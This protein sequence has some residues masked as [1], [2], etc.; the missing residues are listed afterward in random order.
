MKFDGPFV[1]DPHPAESEG[2]DYL[3]LRAINL[4]M[5]DMMLPGINNVVAMIRPFSLMAWVAWRFE[6]GAATWAKVSSTDFELFKQKV[7]TVFVFSH[8]NAGDAEGLPGRQQKVPSGKIIR[9]QFRDFQRSGSILDAALYGPSIKNL[10]G[11]GFLSGSE[12]FQSLFLKVTTSGKRLAL[13]LDKLLR[14]HLSGQQ[15]EFISSLTSTEAPQELIDGKFYSA[16]CISSVSAEEQLAFRERLHQPQTIG[17][18]HNHARRAAV[19]AYAL[20]TLREIGEPATASELRS[21]MTRVLPASLLQTPQSQTFRQ[22]QRHWQLLQVRQAQRLGLEV[23]FGWVERCLLYSQVTSVDNLAEKAMAALQ[24]QPFV[25]EDARYLQLQMSRLR[26]I[27][28]GVD[29]LFAKDR[30]QPEHD[31][32][33]LCDALEAAVKTPQPSD[34]MLAL[35]V[36]LLLI[37]VRFAQAFSEDPITKDEVGAGARFRLPLGMWADFITNHEQ[38]PLSFV[39]HKVFSSF[40]ISQHLGVAASRSRDEKS[41]MRMSIEDRGLTSLLPNAGK[42]LRPKRT[43]DRLPSA[44]ALMAECGLLQ[45]AAPTPN[46]KDVAY[47]VA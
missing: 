28:G 2:V 14:Q 26:A 46:S 8:V 1:V 30:K 27:E 6:E 17:E 9:F 12:A 31:L 43:Q 21:A 41:R 15:Y 16:W 3:G 35:A 32:F 29:E 19:L 18:P 5:M 13:A 39:L 24:V 20:E 23:L 7:E 44:L 33:G 11:L 25:P 36:Q 34:E 37:C 4:S 47:I 42:A 38:Q 10:S 45:K 40:I 22:V